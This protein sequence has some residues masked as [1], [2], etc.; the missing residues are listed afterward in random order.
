MNNNC[1]LLSDFG[2]L[3]GLKKLK[4]VEVL[5]PGACNS[6]AGAKKEVPRML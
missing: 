5:E 1:T 2:D 6:E 4:M 3:T